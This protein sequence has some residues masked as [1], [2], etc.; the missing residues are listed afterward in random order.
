M[1]KFREVEE[2]DANLI[3]DWRT[4]ERVTK[5]MNS[6]IDYDVAGQRQWILSSH[7]KPDYYHWLIQHGGD[8]IGLLNFFDWDQEQK[9]TSW[10]FYIGEDSSLGIGGMIPPYFYNFAFD[11]L[12]VETIKA[13]VFFDN[14]SIIKLHL[15][16]G[17]IFEPSRDHVITKNGK[18]I[19]MVCMILEKNAFKSSRL[20]RLKTKFP[21]AKW[22]GNPLQ[23]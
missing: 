15:A 4:S 22:R 5:F 16:Q 20:S 19:L 10:G 11:Y 8:D 3:L 21:L 9:T 23:S 17:Y 6:D 12:G 2:T 7:E 14:L 13:E 18:D 1:I